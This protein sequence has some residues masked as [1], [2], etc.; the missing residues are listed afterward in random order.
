[1]KLRGNHDNDIVLDSDRA[2]R[3]HVELVRL[4]GDLMLV[5]KQSRNGVW[6]NGR[7]VKEPMAIKSGDILRIGKQEFT[8]VVKE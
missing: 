4:G 2:S 1:M 8:F 6:L 7:R 5:D 3:Y